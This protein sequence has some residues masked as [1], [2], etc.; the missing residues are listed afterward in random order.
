MMSMLKNIPEQREKYN[1]R[2]CFKPDDDWFQIHLIYE[3]GVTKVFLDRVIMWAIVDM[4][5]REQRLDAI[6]DDG[7]PN[8]VFKVAEGDY[9]FVKAS[10]RSPNGKTWAQ[11]YESLT[12]S[13][14]GVRE[15]LAEEEFNFSAG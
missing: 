8:A 6:T 13:L 1:I 14:L 11:I 5:G 7:T 10:D 12:P 15:V 9:Y 2:Q 4:P 3:E